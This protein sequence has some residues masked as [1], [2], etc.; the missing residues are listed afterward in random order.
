MDGFDLGLVHAVEKLPGIRRKGFDVAALAF[1]VEGLEGEA[2]FSRSG[3]AGDDVELAERDVEVEALEVVLAGAPDLD[4][5]R[6]G[7]AGGLLFGSLGFW[8]RH[9]GAQE[10]GVG[11]LVHGGFDRPLGW[12]GIES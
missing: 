12:V 3:R 2:G 8:R 1:G 7:L 10:E 5:G 4:G 11:R 6:R 9:L